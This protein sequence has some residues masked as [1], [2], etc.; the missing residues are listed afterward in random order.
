MFVCA[1]R[2]QERT[3]K[4]KEQ[5]A[6]NRKEELTQLAE[7]QKT[8]TGKLAAAEAKLSTAFTDILYMKMEHEQESKAAAAVQDVNWKENGTY[9]HDME[10]TVWSL[11]CS[12]VPQKRVVDVLKATA[13][14][15]PVTFRWLPSQYL[16]DKMSD[17]LA[18]FA[19]DHACESLMTASKNED[20]LSMLFDGTNKGLKLQKDLMSLAVHSQTY[21]DICLGVQ[22]SRGKGAKDDEEVV[23]QMFST[24]SEASIDWAAGDANIIDTLTFESYVGDAAGPQVAAMARLNKAL[25]EGKGLLVTCTCHH[26]EHVSEAIAFAADVI[27]E[28]QLGNKMEKDE[29]GV[30]QQTHCP[31]TLPEGANNGFKASV[32]AMHETYVPTNNQTTPSFIPPSAVALTGSQQKG[33]FLRHFRPAFR[34]PP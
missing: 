13:S 24:A 10:R 34:L 33:V 7:E 16:I 14:T 22:M 5:L 18:V 20:V 17:S 26:L 32:F 31:D 11:L 23:R 21:G 15:L 1:G 4:L 19:L 30:L 9:S 25:S 2:L 8:M 6:S 3:K 12:G 27:I 29:E 28:E